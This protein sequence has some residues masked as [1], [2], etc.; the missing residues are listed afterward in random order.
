M[1]TKNTRS[2]VDQLG[3]VTLVA[4]KGRDKENVEAM[5]EALGN[6]EH[7]I[8]FYAIFPAGR[9]NDVIFLDGPI[10]EADVA[11]AL[12]KAG[13]SKGHSAVS[14]EATAMK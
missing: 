2:L 5:L 9:P 4:H 13:P 6:K 11:E 1:N 8:P 3:V 14:S 12:N 7:L 10:I